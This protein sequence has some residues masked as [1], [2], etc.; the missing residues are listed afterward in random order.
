MPKF[1]TKSLLQGVDLVDVIA[2]D[3]GDPAK[4]SG[5][6]TFFCCPFHADDDPSFAVTPDRYYCFGC[7]ASGDAIKWLMD[8]RKLTFLDA[9]KTISRHGEGVIPMGNVGQSRPVNLTATITARQNDQPDGFQASWKVIIDECQ[10]LLWSDKGK[11]ARQYLHDRGLNDKTLQSP[12]FRVGYSDGRKVA[13]IWVDRG[14]VLPCFSVDQDSQVEYVDYIKIRHSE[15]VM[16]KYR[17]LK[18]G[19]KGLFGADT[20]KGSDIVIV[21]EGEFDAMLLYQEA[22]DL[23]GVCTLG[24][25]TDRFDWGRYGR[26]IGFVKW[27]LIAYDL[28]DAGDLGAE[29]WKEVSGRV[30]RVKIPDGTGKDITD[31]WKSGV[32][33]SDWVMDVLRENGL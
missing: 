25:A 28:D 3:L 16:P 33:L 32:N 2:S 23:V 11:G 27:I 18:G 17:K 8:Y 20:V 12:F 1:D 26:Y 15:N 10:S 24:S 9:C 19:R 5:R 30:K 6:Y 29:A 21:T 22:G 31:A 13:D 14:I 4:V 7:R